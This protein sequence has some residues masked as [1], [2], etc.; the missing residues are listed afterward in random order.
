[1]TLTVLPN[2]LN[3][4]KLCRGRQTAAG[5]ARF[6]PLGRGAGIRTAALTLAGVL[7]SL[8]AGTPLVGQ[9]SPMARPV[10]RGLA[11][12]GNRALD[13]YTLAI[14]IA[15]SNSSW[16][17]RTGFVSWLGLG[18]QR[19]FDER[20]FRR[21]LVRLQLLYSQSGF[22]EA[23]IDT[24]VQRDSGSVR[25]TF[26]ID[27][28]E[29]VRITELTVMGTEGVISERTLRDRLPL[30][31]GD[32][33]N[34]FRL[35]AATDTILTALA[36]RG[37]PFAQVFRGFDVDRQ[38]HAATVLFDVDPG[39]RARI[40]AVEITGA[41]RVS[42][43]VVRKLIPIREGQWYRR[44]ALFTAQR[45]LYRTGVYDYVD[46]RLRDSLP[47][48]PDDTLVTAQVRLREGRLYRVRTGAGYG[49][50]DC[51]RL[52]AAVTAH[53]FPGAA[54]SLDVTARLS[55]I[56]TG[57]PFPW[58]FQNS[59]CPSLDVEQDSARL[60]LNYNLTAT[61]TEPAL[62]GRRTS[63]ALSVFAE[64]R[65]ELQ[66]YVR[67]AVGGD[68]SLTLRTPWEIPFTLT[69]GLERGSTKA[70]P[71]QFCVYLNI[72]RDE[73][74]AVFQQPLL[75]ATL[76]LLAVRD[77][78]NSFLDPT[79]GS[80]TSAEVR[81]AAPAIGSDTLAQFTRAQAQVAGY[82]RV[83]RRGVFAWRVQGGIIVPPDLGGTAQSLRYVPPEE[84]FY[85]GGPNSVRGYGQNELGPI[86]RVIETRT[87]DNET[88]V[89]TL[90]SASGGNALALA[91][92]E[93]RLPLPVLAGRLEAALFVDAGQVIERGAARTYPGLRIAPGVGIRF[94]TAIGPIRLDVGYNGY[95]PSRGPLYE[96]VGSQLV[97][98]DDDYPGEGDPVPQP[99]FL[100]R[101]RLHF[102]VGQ[103]F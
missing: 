88:I 41:T 30:A 56:G 97:L 45:D 9:E 52:L 61:L 84:R 91:N 78:R 24:V 58:G 39:P 71:A 82:H 75:Q 102:S 44:D 73:D 99:S 77:R 31:V 70:E 3:L 20:E 19:Y 92:V 26:V 67:E 94:V 48:G 54:R 50:L 63:A 11:F 28:G 34:R 25:L 53:H 69:Y 62:F 87:V 65:S 46:V 79:Q 13:D 76:S 55:K 60:A 68:V 36:N 10:I 96:R 5:R 100:D 72:C 64:R 27:E 66:A 4:K 22:L 32:P 86:V 47:D 49:T 38:A 51:F 74:I 37:Y 103:A 95:G 15:T 33:F 93:Y 89:D 2:L 98:L 40:A 90:R 17:A 35:R 59:V 42:P 83:G 85:G 23:S 7:G 6:A 81:W 12:R 29:P 80:L 43:G 57:D 14:S 8:V 1:M 18:E 101:L 16:W 21:D